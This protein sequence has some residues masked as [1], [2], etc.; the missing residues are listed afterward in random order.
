MR[1]SVILMWVRPMGSF[2]LTLF[3]PFAVALSMAIYVYSAEGKNGKNQTKK[4][5]HIVLLRI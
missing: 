2:L 3:S 5:C 4:L 1:M